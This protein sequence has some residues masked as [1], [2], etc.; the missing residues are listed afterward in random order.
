MEFNIAEAQCILPLL[1]GIK[2]QKEEEEKNPSFLFRSVTESVQG[3]VLQ[4]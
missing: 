4:D 3:G 1:E 2:P